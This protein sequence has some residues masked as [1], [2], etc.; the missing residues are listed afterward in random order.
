[1]QITVYI[2][3]EMSEIHVNEAVLEIGDTVM[4]KS[5]LTD[6]EFVGILTAI[7]TREVVLRTGSGPRIS[8]QISQIQGSRISISKIDAESI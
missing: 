1:M 3:E 8:F 4:I 5:K 7:S 6:E 2:N